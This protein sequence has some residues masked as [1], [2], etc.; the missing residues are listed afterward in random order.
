VRGHPEGETESQ[1]HKGNWA[2]NTVTTRERDPLNKA[3]DE[4]GESGVRQ[5]YLR[6]KQRG[7]AERGNKYKGT[8]TVFLKGG[9][10]RHGGV[11]KNRLAKPTEGW[12]GSFVK[13]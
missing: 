2:R 10:S 11:Q 9:G 6:K 3:K 12:S 1:K 8:V 7:G 13:V 4:M 5:K